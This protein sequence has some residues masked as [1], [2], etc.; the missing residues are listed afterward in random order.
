MTAP[1]RAERRF[2][3]CP[4]WLGHC[5]GGV[6]ALPRSWV[7]TANRIAVEC[8]DLRRVAQRQHDVNSGIDFRMPARRLRHA[9]ECI[10]LGEDHGQ[11]TAG[12]Q[13][14]EEHFGPRFL[15]CPLCLL[16]HSLGNE[17]IELAGC[18]HPLHQRHR[19]GGDLKS[20]LRETRGEARDAQIRAPDLRRRP[21]THA[22]AC[23]PP[24]RGCPPYGSMIFAAPRFRPSR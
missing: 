10:D 14:L 18:D 5:S 13:C 19:F 16:P 7:S 2:S 3:S 17:R 6:S 15:Q 22:G 1:P 21:L 20:E 12:A 9:V 8:L 23:V 24:D 4:R 11:R